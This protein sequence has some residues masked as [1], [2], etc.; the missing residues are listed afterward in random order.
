MFGLVYVGFFPEGS[1][2]IY[3]KLAMVFFKNHTDTKSH[4]LAKIYLAVLIF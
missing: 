2:M 1:Q 4:N 3:I